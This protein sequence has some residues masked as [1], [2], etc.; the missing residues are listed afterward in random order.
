[1]GIE[2]A[3]ARNY[4]QTL[5]T[6]GLLPS[7]FC[8]RQGR[9][10]TELTNQLLNYGYTLLTSHVWSALANAG[11]EL[12]AGILHSERAGRPSLVLDMMEEYRAWVVDRNVIK[13]GGAIENAS[14]PTP[15]LKKML[16]V[17]IQETMAK[18]YPYRNKKARLETIMQRQAYRLAATVVDGKPYHPYRFRW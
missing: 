13:M 15:K 7:T 8:G 3:A 5:S 10:A 11:F 2:G 14:R 9:G 12:Y 16:T 18:R 1:M 17:G 4:W 6:T